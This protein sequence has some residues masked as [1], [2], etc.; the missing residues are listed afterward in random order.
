MN[1]VQ[2]DPAL[3]GESSDVRGTSP[4]TATSPGG[5][6]PRFADFEMVRCIGRGNYGEV[7]LARDV[8]GGWRAVKVV[9]RRAFEH[10]RP[11]EREFEGIRK[12][13]PVSRTHPRQLNVIHV[14]RDDQAGCF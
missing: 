9:Y 14:G 7:W 2:P 6:V 13:E 8:I 1:G 11:F 3:R 12:F 10:D 5:A 4:P